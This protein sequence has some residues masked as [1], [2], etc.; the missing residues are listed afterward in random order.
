[1][2]GMFGAIVV[3]CSGGIISEVGDPLRYESSDEKEE[4]LRW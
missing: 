4:M 2:G 1:M 3:S